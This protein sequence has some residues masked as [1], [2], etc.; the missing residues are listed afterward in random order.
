MFERLFFPVT[1]RVRVV[2]DD[3]LG[4]VFRTVAPVALWEELVERLLLLKEL[5]RD[6]VAR[7]FLLLVRWMTALSRAE[8]PVDVR[9]L[10]TVVLRAAVGADAV[11]CVALV[12]ERRDRVL[13]V[14][15]EREREAA[16]CE[17]DVTTI[18]PAPVIMVR[19]R[20][21]RFCTTARR[22]KFLRA[23]G[24]TSPPPTPM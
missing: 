7:T 22:P 2:A 15:S 8:L 18:G 16:R 11:R 3:D 5:E 13:F 17:F 10:V 1:V 9:V 12:T 23:F 20:F 14:I 4:R 6:C 24:S 19:M 21:G